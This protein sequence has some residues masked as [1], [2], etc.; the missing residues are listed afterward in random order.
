M[1]FGNFMWIVVGLTSGIFWFLWVTLKLID[2]DR[3]EKR[4]DY[5]A[6]EHWRLRTEVIKLTQKQKKSK[7]TGGLV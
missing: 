3:I 7:K 6:K 5:W 4:I 2:M 1:S